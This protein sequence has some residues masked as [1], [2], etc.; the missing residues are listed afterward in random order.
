MTQPWRAAIPPLTLALIVAILTA[1]HFAKARAVAHRQ[2]IEAQACRSRADHG[3]ADAEWRLGTMYYSGHGVPQDFT[4][5]ARRYRQSAEQGNKFGEEGLGWCYH[6]GRGVPQDDAQALTLFRKSAVQ[7]SS[8]AENMMA[9][10]Y[11]NG[12]GV[13]PDTVAALGWYHKAISD[14]DT[15][16]EYNLGEMYYFGRGVPIDRK[17]GLRLIRDAANHGDPYAIGSITLPFTPIKRFTLVVVFLF[18]LFFLTEFFYEW[19][20]HANDPQRRRFDLLVA[21]GMAINAA[22]TG[23]TWYGYA[24]HKILCIGRGMNSFTALR[25]ILDI[26]VIVVILAVTRTR[27]RLDSNP[28]PDPESL[29][30]MT[31]TN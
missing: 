18:S 7:G 30:P 17:E 3:D 12:Q 19:P 24:H 20:A 2:L 5:A 28:T 29:T 16:A 13:A 22:L 27:K 14:G 11:E 9:L 4:E 21:A 1:V 26:L 31:E 6:A 23:V 25:W 10:L 8:K 15:A